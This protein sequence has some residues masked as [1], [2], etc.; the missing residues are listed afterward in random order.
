MRDAQRWL[1]IDA[2]MF[3]KRFIDD[4]YD[5]FGWA[6]IVVWIAFL[7][8]C[9]KNRIPGRIRVMNDIQAAT[10]L[11]LAQWDLVDNKGAPWTLSEFWAFTGRKKQTRQILVQR[12]DSS[13]TRDGRVTDS[14]RT[15]HGRVRDVCATH[16]ERWQNR[17]SHHTNRGP[18]GPLVRGGAS[19]DLDLDLDLDKKNPKPQTGG[20]PPDPAPTSRT[21]GTNPRDRGT[22]PRAKG[23]NPRA[24][25]EPRREVIPDWQPDPEPAEPSIDRGAVK[26]LRNRPQP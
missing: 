2:D 6:G 22:N 17:T 9:K 12:R 15:A 13:R 10:E 23:T 20:D 16:W 11:G 5:E 7:C 24:K 14:S 19:A 21:N 4:L 18:A 8:A 1:A 25:T 3:G 26:A